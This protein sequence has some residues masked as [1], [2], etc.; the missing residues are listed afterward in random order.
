[1]YEN[2]FTLKKM[3]VAYAKPLRFDGRSSRTELLGYFVV[4]GLAAT[5]LA[6]LALGFG[7]AA[8]LSANPQPFMTIDVFN[9]MVWLPFPALAV[10]RFHDQSR[11]AWWATPLI[12]SSVL[13]WLGGLSLLGGT[14]RIILWLIY[15][16]AFVLLF[17]KPTDGTNRFGPDPRLDADGAL[18]PAE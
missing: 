16:I 12:F 5:V 14:A 1:M 13:S 2:S 8:T 15:L 6:W 17:W 3:L 4:S 10:R 18:I 11:S 7:I 9:L